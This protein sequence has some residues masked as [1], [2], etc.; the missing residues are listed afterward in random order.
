MLSY[1]P[2][3]N[4]RDTIF[5]FLICEKFDFNLTDVAATI[6]N[7]YPQGMPANHRHNLILSIKDGM[8]T[9]YSENENGARLIVPYSIF[10]GKPV[11]TVFVPS[12]STDEHIIAFASFMFT[13]VSHTVLIQPD[14]ISYLM[15]KHSNGEYA[16]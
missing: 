10:Y 9:Y 11:K 8:A 16:I 3:N 13:G 1:D 15:F 4:P 12:S 7:I 14:I 2:I 5:T 6:N